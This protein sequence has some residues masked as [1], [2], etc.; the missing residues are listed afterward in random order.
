VKYNEK[1]ECF[2]RILS[3]YINWVSGYYWQAKIPFSFVEM[4]WDHP[5]DF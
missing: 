3:G 2:R 5:W 1:L 4:S